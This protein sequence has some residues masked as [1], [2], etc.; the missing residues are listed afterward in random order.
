MFDLIQ[1]D[2]SG[3]CNAKCSWCISGRKNR[4]HMNSGGFMSTELFEKTVKHLKKKG[5]INRNGG[6]LALYMWGDPFIHPK[7]KEIMSIAHQENVQVGISTNGSI[8]ILFDEPGVLSNVRHIWFSMPGFSQSSYD[9]SHGFNF[10][11]I[12]SNIMEMVQNF[13]DIGGLEKGAI[14]N[15]FH[16]YQYNL[17]EIPAALE[18]ANKIGVNLWPYA[19]FFNDYELA[20]A[21]LTKT[22][23]YDTLEKAGKEL[24]L[25]AY[26]RKITDKPPLKSPPCHRQLYLDEYANVVTCCF[27]KHIKL[28][29]IFDM[30]PPD[31]IKL[32]ET[33]KEA[34]SMC[35]ECNQLGISRMEVLQLRE[36]IPL[37]S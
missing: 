19:A 28:G 27:G 21:F 2:I 5:F 7:I 12:K 26:D 1:F 10:D 20:K 13:Y 4:E 34:V 9:R 24:F 25:F 35:N 29:S 30:I 18:F 31:V 15:I 37:I 14:S 23:N 33:N 16:M 17:L 8:K 6:Y 32:K 36:F 22:L 11:T 3:L